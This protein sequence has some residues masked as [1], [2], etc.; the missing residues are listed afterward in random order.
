MSF[1]F[2]LMTLLLI[3][4]WMV[5]TFIQGYM[6]LQLL[7]WMVP[8]CY[9]EL[10]AD[11][12]HRWY[13][14][15]ITDLHLRS[16]LFKKKTSKHIFCPNFQCILMKYSNRMLH[17]IGMWKLVQSFFH[18]IYPCGRQPYFS[19]VTN[20][21]SS[22]LLS[23]PV[24]RRC[25][26]THTHAFCPVACAVWILHSPNFMTVNKALYQM[27]T[28]FCLFYVHKYTCKKNPI[29]SQLRCGC[30]PTHTHKEQILL[31][32]FRGCMA[33]HTVIRETHCNM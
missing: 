12:F 18:M 26:I 7:S 32:V 25:R 17:H 6:K 5:L 3:V 30:E 15:K 2:S 29:K 14:V 4:V 16:H 28:K 8:D 1:K 22:L 9:S 24:R 21:A 20:N 33:T 31:T 11:T 27:P 10:I 13:H 19:L 23:F